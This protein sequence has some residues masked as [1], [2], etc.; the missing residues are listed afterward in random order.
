MATSSARPTPR[1]AGR[2]SSA[3]PRGLELYAIAVRLVTTLEATWASYL[4]ERKMRQL[5][6]LLAELWDEIERRSSEDA[7]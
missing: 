7:R 2:G 6:R 3:S 1:T 5:K 4:G